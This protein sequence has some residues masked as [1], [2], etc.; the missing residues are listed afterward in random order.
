MECRLQIHEHP[1]VARATHTGPGFR[2]RLCLRPATA[3]AAPHTIERRHLG[4]VVS[5]ALTGELDL[6]AAARAD[7]EPREAG[8][9]A[10]FVVWDLRDL[11][12][13]DCAGLWALRAAGSLV[14]AI[15][16]RMVIVHIPPQAR[17]LLG[18]PGPSKRLR[19]GRDPSARDI[20]RGV[21]SLRAGRLEM[22]DS[23]AR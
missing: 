23:D 18:L 12:F 4:A 16:R 3:P 2:R 7:L 6:A 20:G 17:R 22:G 21:R 1:H 19:V 15:G 13:V 9:Q 5:V 14:R 11:T 10:E 8:A